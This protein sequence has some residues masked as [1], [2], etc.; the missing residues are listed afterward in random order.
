LAVLVTAVQPGL[1]R[2]LAARPKAARL[3]PGFARGACL[4]PSKPFGVASQ[5]D[6]YVLRS[7]AIL[8]ALPYCRVC[9][10]ILLIAVK[11]HIPPRLALASSTGIATPH[12][13]VQMGR[14]GGLGL[15]VCVWHWNLELTKPP[16]ADYL[17][18]NRGAVAVA[19]CPYSTSYYNR[20]I[21]KRKQKH[22]KRPL[23]PG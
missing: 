6:V 4:L 21:K 23:V 11:P 19:A 17:E 3:G 22:K 7:Y 5:V 14:P 16:K 2:C 13:Q 15:F 9:Y 18:G 1:R 8:S 20:G 10:C 12:A